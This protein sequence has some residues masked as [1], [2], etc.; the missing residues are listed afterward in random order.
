MKLGIN[1]KPQF[2]SSNEELLGVHRGWGWGGADVGVRVLQE[3]IL[4]LKSFFLIDDGILV[5]LR[6]FQHYFSH[7]RK[8]GG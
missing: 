4:S 7:I 1:I 2:G 6:P 3:Q 8:I 5:I